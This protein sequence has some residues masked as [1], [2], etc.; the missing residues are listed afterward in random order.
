MPKAQLLFA[1]RSERLG[2]RMRY[3][4]EASRKAARPGVTRA[5]ADDA[6][7]ARKSS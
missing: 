2:E 6:A 4:W 7:A 1:E 5:S 3:L